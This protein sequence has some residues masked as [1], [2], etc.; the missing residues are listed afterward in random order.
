MIHLQES[1]RDAT[2]FLWLQNPKY[3]PSSSNIRKMRFTRVPFGTKA[4]P[5]LLAMSIKYYLEQNHQTELRSEILR[6][7]YVDNVLLLADTIEEAVDKYR[8][9]KAIF[10]EMSMNLREFVTNDPKVVAQISEP[11]RSHSESLKVLR[12]SWNSSTDGLVLRSQLP[13]YDVLTKRNILRIFHCTFDPLGLLVPLLLPARVFLQSLWLKKYDWDQPIAE[14]ETEQWNA[15]VRNADNFEKVIPRKLGL[16]REHGVYEICTFADASANAYA[17]CTYIRHVSDS[18]IETNILCAKYRLA[19]VSQLT[20]NKTCT[21]PKLGLLA[22]LIASQLTDFV[23]R[24]LDLPIS[25]IRIFSDSKIVLHQ[26]H[27]GKMQV[28]S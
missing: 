1:Q 2:R 13:H 15:I 23:R 16:L 24:E 26:V 12:V 6:N 7:L 20:S 11:D 3:P 10:M 14:S 9:T 8:K 19:P 4:S 27:T 25:K 21:I 17:A 5:S 28:P 18:S 22:L